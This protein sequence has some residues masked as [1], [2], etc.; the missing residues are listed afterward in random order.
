MKNLL[1]LFAAVIMATGFAA[2][3]HAVTLNFDGYPTTGGLAGL[4]ANQS[5]TYTG[6]QYVFSTQTDVIDLTQI[7]DGGPGAVSGSNALLNLN[8]GAIAITRVGGGAFDFSDLWMRIYSADP[9]S[10]D[11]SITGS[12]GAAAN[13]P[14]TVSNGSWSHLFASLT[15]VTQVVID[16]PDFAGVNFL[17]DDITLTSAAGTGGGDDG[18]DDGHPA[19]VPEPSTMALLGAGLAG[20]AAWRKRKQSAR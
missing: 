4:G 8:G 13:S 11:V 1:T 16:T 2:T 12:N 7:T 19:P 14:F 9:L 15:N 3:S 10:V 6:T 5:F 17:L 18:G 20:F